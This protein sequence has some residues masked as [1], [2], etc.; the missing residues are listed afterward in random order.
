MRVPNTSSLLFSHAGRIDNRYSRW[1]L[2]V[3]RSVD[4][5]A[6]WT[7]AVQIEHLNATELPQLH[8][9]YS[10]LLVLSG[11]PNQGSAAGAGGLNAAQAPVAIA[12]ERGPEQGSHITPSSCGEYATIRWKTFQLP[13]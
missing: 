9:A 6:T 12:Y 4:S 3:W 7:A 1:N 10:T 2:T 11:A 5:G 8:T 13:T